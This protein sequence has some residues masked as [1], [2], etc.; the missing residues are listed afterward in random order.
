MD[1]P[2]VNVLCVQTSAQRSAGPSSL[3]SLSWSVRSGPE[4]RGEICIRGALLMQHYWK[5]PEKTAE[6]FA[7]GEPLGRICLDEGSR[8]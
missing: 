2:F 3:R 6:T 1:L 8:F 4:E 5:K 7:P